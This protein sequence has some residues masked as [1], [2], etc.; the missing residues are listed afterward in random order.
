MADRIQRVAEEVKR[1]ISNILRNE[2]RDPRFPQMLTVL[3]ARVTK[4]LRHANV[5]ISIL[6]D[7]EKKK[8]AMDCLANAKGFIKKELS[9]R[10]RLRV[11][12]EVHFEL[13]ETIERGM[14]M[15]KVIDNVLEEQKDHVMLKN[16]DKV[17]ELIKNADNIAIL[18]H[19]S[20]DGD[21]VGSSLALWL[22]LSKFGKKVTVYF[23]EEIP[24]TYKFLH[25][26]QRALVYLEG[27]EVTA[28]L[29]I[30][31]D[32]GSEDRL[33][34]R[35]KIYNDAK[36][37]V[38][39]DHH[40]TNE[41]FAKFNFVDKDSAATGEIVYKLI[42]QLGYGED[43]QIAECLYV[44]IAADTGGFRFSNTTS[45]THSIISSLLTSG[46]DS[47][48][49]SQLIFNSVPVNTSK[50]LGLALSGMEFH[51]DGKIVLI[52]I[53][54]EMMKSIGAKDEDSDGLSG[55]G[56]NIEGVEVSVVLKCRSN[57]EIKVSMRSKSYVDVSEIAL[58]FGGGGHKR[59]A[60]CAIKGQP[61]QV[62]ALVLSAV[63]EKVG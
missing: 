21:A 5:R 57:G 11:T 41:G 18:P 63:L 29:V 40:V 6:G 20:L 9:H 33:G 34:N 24:V 23:E 30:C 59:A 4:D 53:T 55:T 8:D 46:I 61:D 16:L 7:A 47:A 22:A 27:Q 60:G 49:L 10:L 52:S 44:A 42:K 13:D 17:L 2:I 31:I 50:L 56:S 15:A 3:S 32:T 25:R 19:I 58:K 54:E 38:S 37:T 39:I 45:E 1:E 51:A 35:A 12:P 28:D 48:K 36:I 62:K 26:D 43:S 14:Y